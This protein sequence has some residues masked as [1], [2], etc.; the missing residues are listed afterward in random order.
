[1][2]TS[3]EVL[4]LGN[5]P[6]IDTSEGDQFVS[7]AAVASWLGTY[8]SQTSPLSNTAQADFAPGRFVQTA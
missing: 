7:Q 6:L 8:G 5:L 1:M 4:F 2:A 3:F